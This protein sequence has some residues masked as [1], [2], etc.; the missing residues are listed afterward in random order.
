MGQS[1]FQ[2]DQ[3]NLVINGPIDVD[4]IEEIKSLHEDYNFDDGGYLVL[5][6]TE[7]VLPKIGNVAIIDLQSFDIPHMVEKVTGGIGRYACLNFIRKAED[8]F[9]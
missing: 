4:K 5:Q 8:T 7:K 9:K 1:P 2:E 6:N 3:K